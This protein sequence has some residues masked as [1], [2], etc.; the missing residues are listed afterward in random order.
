MVSPERDSPLPSGHPGYPPCHHY[1]AKSCRQVPEP[2]DGTPIL[3]LLSL[4]RKLRPPTAAP[5]GKDTVMK[6]SASAVWNGILKTGDGSV[7]TESGALDGLAYS[8]ATRFENEPGSNP[9]ELIGAAHAGCF[10]MAFANILDGAGMSPESIATTADVTMEPVDGAPTIS[11][12]HLTVN[13]KVPGA[14]PEAFQKAAEEAKAG[15]PVSRVLNAEV[16][17]DATLEA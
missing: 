9:E 16:T 3:F 11:K 2:P 10:S 14:A 5:A 8:F 15:C 6:R 17:M 4:S 13:A 7:S 1:R 12:I